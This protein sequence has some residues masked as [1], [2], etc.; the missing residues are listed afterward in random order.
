MI[1]RESDL[2]GAW[3][4]EIDPREDERG[5]FARTFCAEEFERFGLESEFRQCSVSFNRSRGTLRG[6]HFQAAPNTEAKLVRC[7]QGRIFDVIVDIRPNAA[8]LGRWFGLELSASKRNALFIPEGL[9]HGFMTLEDDAEVFYQISRSFVTETARG[10]RWND[11]RIGIS[12]PMEP[13]VISKRD[14]TLPPLDSLIGRELAP[15]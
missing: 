4:V 12:W 5:L 11:S 7:T 3:I 10:V 9:A 2:P 8:T 14:A 15:K 6:L 1:F 13:V